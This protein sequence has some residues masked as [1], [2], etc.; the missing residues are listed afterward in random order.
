MVFLGAIGLFRRRFFLDPKREG[1]VHWRSV[2]LQFAKWPY[3]CIAAW[4]AIRQTTGVYTVT[5]K[6]RASGSP[7]LMLSP[8]WVVVIIMGLAVSTA[9]E[10]RIPPG[11][12]IVLGGA[13]IVVASAWIALSEFL[14]VPHS[15]DGTL[16]T[17]RRAELSDILGPE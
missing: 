17:R 2:L 13:A 16:Y 6:L 7:W 4:R 1:G 8:H 5:L 3:Q 10:L 9:V 14:P 12:P 15:W 11:T